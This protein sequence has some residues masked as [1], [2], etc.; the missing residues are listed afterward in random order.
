[1]VVATIYLDPAIPQVTAKTLKSFENGEFGPIFAATPQPLS[2]NYKTS[3][4]SIPG[5]MSAIPRTSLNAYGGSTAASMGYARRLSTS[6][7]PIPQHQPQPPA[8]FGIPGPRGIRLPEDEA[9]D[10]D[11]E[12]YQSDEIE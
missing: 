6:T 4:E 1:M 12:Y 5:G 10:E 11:G 2:S 7:S 9:D 3:S 8:P